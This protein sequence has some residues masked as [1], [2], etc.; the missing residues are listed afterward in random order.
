M[1]TVPDKSTRQIGA[2]DSGLNHRVAQPGEE[3]SIVAGQAAQI[4]AKQPAAFRSQGLS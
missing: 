4:A 3:T 2:I 1:E